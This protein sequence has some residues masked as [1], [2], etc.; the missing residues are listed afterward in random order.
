MRIYEIFYNVCSGQSLFV[1]CFMYYGL[2]RGVQLF[3][4]IIIHN[5]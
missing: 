4:N 3:I 1:Y 5:Q 2:H